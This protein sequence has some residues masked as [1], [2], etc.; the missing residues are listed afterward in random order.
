[1]PAGIVT[2]TIR[3]VWN[4]LRYRMIQVKWFVVL[5]GVGSLTDCRT[6]VCIRM[7]LEYIGCGSKRWQV[8]PGRPESA[9][10]SRV[11]TSDS[12]EVDAVA[13]RA[14][15]TPADNIYICSSL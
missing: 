12:M 15:E 8:G 5:E 1:M 3:K 10:I 9:A 13:G 2:G 6:S 11:S 7:I 4:R 14:K